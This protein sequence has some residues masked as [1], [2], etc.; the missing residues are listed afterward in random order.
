MHTL[1]NDQSVGCSSAENFYIYTSHL[2]A[3][4]LMRNQDLFKLSNACVFNQYFHGSVGERIE[5]S[6]WTVN[7]LL[8]KQS[9]YWTVQW[10]NVLNIIHMV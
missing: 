9:G 4:T 8:V 3:L 2:I 10:L 5:N 6:S 7:F 1:E